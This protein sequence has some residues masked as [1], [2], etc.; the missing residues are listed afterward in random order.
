MAMKLQETHLIDQGPV[1]GNL[2]VRNAGE[3]DPLHLDQPAGGLAALEWSFMRAAHC[4]VN[5]DNSMVIL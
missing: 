5:A 4:P 1:F 2:A 3:D